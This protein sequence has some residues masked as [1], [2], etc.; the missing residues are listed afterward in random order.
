MSSPE[1][2]EQ[3]IEEHEALISIYDGD[4][5]FK[6]IS[7]TTFQY[8]VNRNE[9]NDGLSVFFPQNKRIPFHNLVR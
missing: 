7:P 1:I 8:R 5:A 6:A 3:Q 4:N 9:F 2:K